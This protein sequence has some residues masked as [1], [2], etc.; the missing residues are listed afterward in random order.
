M[1]LGFSY[2]LRSVYPDASFRLAGQPRRPSPHELHADFL[3]LLINFQDLNLVS[4]A[5]PTAKQLGIFLSGAAGVL[6]V[7]ITEQYVVGIAAAVKQIAAVSLVRDDGV[8][9][10]DG[11]ERIGLHAG[12]RLPDRDG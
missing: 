8:E 1:V 10:M 5:G 3:Q 7:P 2:R 11:R 6:G 4:Q 12:Q 9:F